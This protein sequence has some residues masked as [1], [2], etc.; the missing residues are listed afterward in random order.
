MVPQKPNISS[1]ER[2]LVLALIAFVCALF[3]WQVQGLYIVTFPF[4]LF[5]TMIHELGH[6][7]S[8]MITGGSFLRFEVT[9]RGAGVAYTSGGSRFV[10]IQAGYLGASVFGAV[11]LIL[12]NRVSRPGVVAIGLG[13]LIGLLT[14]LYSGISVAGVNPLEAI[15]VAGAFA[16]ATFLILTRETN[17]GRLLGLGAAAA[18]AVLLA[19][20]AG[21]GHI[22][23]TISVGV[24][25]A[26]LLILI[27]YRASRDV[28]LI[29][30]NFLA[31][32]TGLQA[33]T[34]AW[35]LF[36]IVSLPP[37]M[38]PFNDA[39]SMSHAFGG[40]ASLWAV[41]WIAL[42]I[43]IFGVTVYL[44]FIRKIRQSHKTPQAVS[45]RS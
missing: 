3:L 9:E 41:V 33:I 22:L 29:T 35:V 18:G 26:F 15:L 7:T 11:L 10:I 44:I 38:M 4:R 20:F 39:A 17:Q 5:V 24:C 36:K 28:V 42:D 16:V 40:S 27:G 19:V 34:D 31:F 6:G 2:D 43:L 13:V 1:P 14:L 21:W 8:A 32:L 23:L 45:L 30:L 12:A 25:S 37:S